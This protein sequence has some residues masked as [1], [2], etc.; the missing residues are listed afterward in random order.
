[1]TVRWI[2]YHQFAC[3]Y[4][5]SEPATAWICASDTQVSA[6]ATLANYTTAP[7]PPRPI[8]ARPNTATP[9][10]LTNC[11]NHPL[12]WAQFVTFREFCDEGFM[13]WP[14]EI[15]SNHRKTKH[16]REKR[17]FSRKERKRDTGEQRL[18]SWSK[19]QANCYLLQ[20]KLICSRFALVKFILKGKHNVASFSHADNILKINIWA[21]FSQFLN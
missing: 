7:L 10:Q 15:G 21:I 19:L 9:C 17:K 18:A 13:L 14:V 12:E 3:K 8:A 16:T 11:H 20:I 6:A 2:K 4:L 5:L 1:M